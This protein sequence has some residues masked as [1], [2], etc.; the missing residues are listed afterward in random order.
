MSKSQT[1]TQ[2]KLSAL[3]TKHRSIDVHQ[4]FLRRQVSVL[5][6]THPLISHVSG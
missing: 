6:N 5:L 1:E 4:S 2:H 3:G